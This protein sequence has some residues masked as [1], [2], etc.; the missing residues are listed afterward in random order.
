MPPPAGLVSKL[1][2]LVPPPAGL[3]SKLGDLVPLP[4]D[5]VGKLGNLVPSSADLVGGLANLIPQPVGFVNSWWANPWRH[6]PADIS[7]KRRR[8]STV[9]LIGRF[10]L[11]IPIMVES[12]VVP[13][14]K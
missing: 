1:G 2:D 10:I 11:A 9:T 4:V 5:L 3:V 14:D 12:A 8:G 7:V 13:L 6:A